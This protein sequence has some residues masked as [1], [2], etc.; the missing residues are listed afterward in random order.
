M[1]HSRRLK[2]I[3]ATRDQLGRTPGRCKILGEVRASS[4]ANQ[5]CWCD[6]WLSNK[7]I[8]AA[9][10][11]MLMWVLSELKQ[12]WVLTH[13]EFIVAILNQKKSHVSKNE[14]GFSHYIEYVDMI[15]D[16]WVSKLI[17]CSYIFEWVI[18]FYLGEYICGREYM[19]RVLSK[20]KV[21]LWHFLTICVKHMK[22]VYFSK[23][24][25]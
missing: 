3:N 1:R 9:I 7:F 21:W 22:K 4:E 16:I 8:A 11:N 10:L 15:F 13:I 6:I 20:W 12:M 19:G 23:T 24:N 18:C 2:S 14:C 5:I 17:Y 25:V